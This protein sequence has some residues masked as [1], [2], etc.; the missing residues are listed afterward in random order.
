[1]SVN[2]ESAGGNVAAALELLCHVGRQSLFC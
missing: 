2:V 1:M